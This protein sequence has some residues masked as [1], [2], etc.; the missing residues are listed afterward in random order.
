MT[1]KLGPDHY[2]YVTHVDERGVFI[3]CQRFVVVGETAY[4]YYVVN[5]S[6][7]GYLACLSGPARQRAIKQNR[8]RVSK[9]GV[10]RHCYPDKRLA[11]NSMVARQRTRIWHAN[12]NLSAAQLAM[13]EASRLLDAGDLPDNR[14]LCGHDEF[15]ASITW[16]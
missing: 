12:L 10:A 2:R 4:F 8:K 15:T 14:H 1:D 11:L 6:Y 5:E 7:H 16:D 3:V 9:H 13:A